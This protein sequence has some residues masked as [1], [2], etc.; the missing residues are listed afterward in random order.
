[1]TESNPAVKEVYIVEYHI[2]FSEEVGGRLNGSFQTEGNLP[3]RESLIQAIAGRHPDL[4]WKTARKVNY[5]V[6]RLMNN[7][8]H[9]MEEQGE[10]SP[11]ELGG[12]AGQ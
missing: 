6:S 12:Q 1:M 7:N 11:Q 10:F 4:D 5:T 8:T 2:I 9:I 3:G